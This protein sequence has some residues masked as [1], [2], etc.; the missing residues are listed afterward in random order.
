MIH[1]GNSSF[2]FFRKGANGWNSIISD[3]P[4]EFLTYSTSFGI[5]GQYLILDR[6]DAPIPYTDCQNNRIILLDG[7]IFNVS[8]L[9]SEL[10][11]NHTD[12][13]ANSNIIAHFIEEWQ[14]KIFDFSMI[15]RKLYDLIEGMFAGAL[16]LKNYIFLFRDLIGIKPLYLYSGP[17]YIAFASE[18]KA[19]WAAGFTTVHSLQPGRVVRAAEKGFTSHFQADLKGNEFIEN[20]FEYYSEAILHSLQENLHELKPGNPFFLLLSGGID[21]TLLAACLKRLNIPFNSL[22]VGDEKSKDIQKAQSAADFLGIPLDILNFD[23]E[24]LE[25]ILPFL[26]YYSESQE[27]KKLNIAFPLFYASQYLK[28]R[29]IRVAFTG[30]GADELFAGYERHVE[31][32]LHLGTLQEALWADIQSLSKNNLQRD[33]AVSMAHTIELRLPYLLPK[34]VELSMQVPPSFK[35]HKFTRK[36]IL[37]KIAENLNLPQNI[38]QEAKHA[39]QFSSGSYNNL[40]KLAKQYGFDKNFALKHGFL[41]P[42]QLF[43]DS[44]AYILGFPNI[45]SQVIKLVEKTS[46]TLPDSVFSHRNLVNQT[47]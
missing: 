22:V 12:N 32:A 35:V 27:E 1:R 47:V 45:N 3:N 24:T 9:K 25:K 29:G 19:L 37:R 13:I 2:C 6:E 38:T 34:F 11:N 23:I 44:I 36:Y 4:E 17:K 28:N 42:T 16:I 21:S 8:E 30:Q 40:R 26:I 14:S 7:R 43:I 31:F 39:I 46:I 20:S 5:I 15:F 33:D 18:Q 10:N 41:S